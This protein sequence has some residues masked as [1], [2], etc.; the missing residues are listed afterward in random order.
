VLEKGEIVEQ[1]SHSSLLK[2]GGLYAGMW[3]R[4]REA[5]EAREMLVSAFGEDDLSIAK[6]VE[7][8]LTDRVE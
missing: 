3:E 8:I 4:Q 5:D 7:S 1:G 6:P 2:Q